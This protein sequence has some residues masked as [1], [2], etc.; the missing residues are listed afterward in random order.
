MRT[1]TSLKLVSVGLAL[2]LLGAACGTDDADPEAT[3]SP[4]ATA[5]EGP[6]ITV[7]S[8]NFGESRILAEI[9][10]QTL[11]ANGYTVER[12][13]DLGTR[14][15]ILP[16]IGDGA[17]DLLPEYISAAL[18]NGF[19]LEP[20]FD[21]SEGTAALATAFADTHGAVLLEPAPG[22][23]K[24]AYVTSRDFASEHNLVT[25][26]D[27]ANADAVVFQGPPECES[28]DTCLLGLTDAYGL[29]N[30]TFEAV[31]EA[32]VRVENLK[33]GNANLIRLFSTQPVIAVEDFVTLEDDMAIIGVENIIPVISGEVA[34][35]YGQDLQDILNDVSALITTEVLIELNRRVEVDLE[36][37]ADVAA[38]FLAENA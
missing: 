13:L 32:G 14:E 6:A 33:A 37:A 22:E 34:D 5:V 18:V 11:E 38:A 4:S 25:I 9:Y 17:I 29:T 8:F 35:A 27:L 20:A 3:G 12:S 15:E 10:A 7:G 24:D 16:E 1:R 30:I 23:D 36:D 26:S 28:R 31:A 2:G 19:G 21:A